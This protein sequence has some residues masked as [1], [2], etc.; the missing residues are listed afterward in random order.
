MTFKV[1]RQQLSVLDEKFLPTCGDVEVDV[2]A[3]N[4]AENYY[5]FFVH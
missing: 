5:Y 4:V 3:F 1:R 2:N